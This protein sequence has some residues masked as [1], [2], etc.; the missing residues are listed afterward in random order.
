MRVFKISVKVEHNKH[1]SPEDADFV[2]YFVKKS[3]EDVILGYVEEQN[4]ARYDPIKY[5]KG[6]LIRK[7]QLVFA[8]MSNDERILPVCYCFNN[9]SK[10]GI[11]SRLSFNNTFFYLNQFDGYATVELKEIET[12]KKAMQIEWKT[13]EIFKDREMKATQEN[14]KLM[15][16]ADEFEVYFK[17]NN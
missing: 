1:W 11:W 9:L 12:L 13:M 8:K 15:R 6:I 4:D 16:N 7:R 10:M 2:G 3:N 14:K 5:V 17:I